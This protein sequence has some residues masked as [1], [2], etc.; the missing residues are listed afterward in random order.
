MSEAEQ[1]APRKRRRSVELVAPALA[2]LA[3]GQY[4]ERVA[5]AVGVS[6]A[7]VLNWMDW[8]WKH[9][10]EL[11]IYLRKH[12]PDLSEEEIAALW[13]RIER[14]RI[15]RQRRLDFRSLLSHR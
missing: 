2:L 10:Q 12:Y 8:A 7:T 5:Q 13:L 6:T 1:R 9:R 15:K 14:R 3:Q 11:D 4:A